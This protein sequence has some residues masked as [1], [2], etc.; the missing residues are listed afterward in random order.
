[1]ELS[2]PLTLDSRS[3]NVWTH[4]NI[5]TYSRQK[6]RL[7]LRER[8]CMEKMVATHIRVVLPLYISVCMY[9]H[10]QSIAIRSRLTSSS[11]VY[12]VVDCSEEQYDSAGVS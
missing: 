8:K 7:F 9:L 4:C 6:E 11:V 5:A 10:L 3:A 12:R 2:Y 1:M